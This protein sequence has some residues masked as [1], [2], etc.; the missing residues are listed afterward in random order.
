LSGFGGYRNMTETKNHI[1]ESHHD[2]VRIT[3]NEHHQPKL[4]FDKLCLEAVTIERSVDDEPWDILAKNVRSPYVDQTSPD[5]AG[6]VKYRIRFGKAQE[7][8]VELTVNFP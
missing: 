6:Q 4:Y 8:S 7:E 2:R 5:H 1:P 3:L